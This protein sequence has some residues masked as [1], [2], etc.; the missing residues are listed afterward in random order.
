MPNGGKELYEFGPFRL[1]PAKRLLLRENQPVPIQ[2]KAFETLLVLVRNSEQVVLK[3][4]LMKAVW[5]DTFVEES[6]LAQNIFV[7]RK[8]LSAAGDSRYIVTIPGRGYSFTGKVRVVDEEESLVV[9]TRSRMRVVVEEESFPDVNTAPRETTTTRYRPRQKLLLGAAVLAAAVAAFIFRPQVSPP[10]VTRV[11]QITHLGTLV[12]NTKLVT[13]GPRIYFRAWESKERV[14]RYVS[15]EGG[16]VFPV[17]KAFPNMDIDDIS[18]NGS[19]LLAVDLRDRRVASNPDDDEPSLWRV[20]LPEGSP[21]RVGDIYSRDARWSPDGQS[22]V[23]TAGND[24]YL[25]NPDGSNSRKLASLPG[26][27]F[28]PLWSPDGKRLRVAVGDPSGSG[29]TL[30][31]VDTAKGSARP[32][33]PE[34]PSSQH[35]LPGGWTPDGKYFF[36][37][38]LED[39]TTRN[40]WAIREGEILRRA[41]PHPQPITTGPLTFYVPLPSKD[42]KSVFAVGEQLRGQLLRYDSTAKHFAP[43]AQ[44]IS[45]DHIA[46]SRDG[47]WMAYAEF[48]TGVLVRSRADGSERRQLTFPPMRAFGPQWSPDGAQIAFQGL[49][50]A[51]GRSQ[52]YLISANGGTPLPAAPSPHER[53]RF[54]SWTSDGASILYSSSDDQDSNPE[55]RILNAA[56]K[57]IATL[58]NTAGLWYAQLSPNGQNIVADERASGHL[59]IYDMRSHQSRLL[60]DELSDYIQWSADG[61]FVYFNSPYWGSRGIKGGVYRWNFS[62]NKTELV[63]PY[64]DFILTGL[65]GVGYTVTPGGEILLLRDVSTRDLYA[66]DMELP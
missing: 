15:P 36:Y 8:A 62:S 44:N 52:I 53:Q 1:D 24:L 34:V 13:D 48:P 23:C 21:R 54:P 60:T 35:P 32:F 59:M 38:T 12:H 64:P 50:Q 22:I 17:E 33:L 61:N 25:V 2:L 46:F 55:L 65:Y 3:E 28:H 37:S 43:Y 10:R 57:E 45:A 66:L 63:A 30:W 29:T 40:L 18:P 7:L 41:N 20:P 56:T 27:P 47:K 6:N 19:E 14:I 16:D 5:P 58:P 26:N 31:Q 51:G 11:R 39:G 4:D 42:G 9:A 49:S